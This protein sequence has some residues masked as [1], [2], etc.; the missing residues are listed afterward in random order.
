MGLSPALEGE[1]LILIRN[2]QFSPQI[3]DAD[4]LP[5]VEGIGRWGSLD[6]Q[7]CSPFGEE[8][9]HSLLL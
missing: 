3:C 7:V 2:S 8:K 6:A 5:A 1:G 4:F 9:A